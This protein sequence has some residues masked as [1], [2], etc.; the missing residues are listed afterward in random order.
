MTKKNAANRRLRRHFFHWV[1]RKLMDN[2]EEYRN[3]FKY[4]CPDGIV[5]WMVPV[6]S[7]GITDW[8]EGQAMTMTGAGATES[9][10]N[11]RFCLHPTNR[12][13]ITENGVT[14]PRRK[15]EETM[16]LTEEYKHATQTLRA[17]RQ[18]CLYYAS[19]MP[20]SCAHICDYAFSSQS[21]CIWKKTVSGHRHSTLTST[22]SMQCSPRISCIPFRKVL[23]ICCGEF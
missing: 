17:A 9:K 4:R 22:E 1:V 15:Q 18:V 19:I 2:I 8:P 3:G 16:Q 11:C 13:A 20:P 5:R 6:L 10:C 21:L 14:Y 7:F 23:W 12:M